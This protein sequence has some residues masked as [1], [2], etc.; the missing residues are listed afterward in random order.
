MASAAPS[1]IGARTTPWLLAAYCV[2]LALIGFW[3][4]PVD[5][6]AA[7]TLADLFRFLH[8][9]GVPHWIN[10]NFVEFSANILLFVPFGLLV[11]MVSPTRRWWMAVVLGFVISLGLETAQYALLS[12]RYPSGLDVLAN[13]T[14]ASLGGLTVFLVRRRRRPTL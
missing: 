2:C 10:Y 1:L 13:T 6:P 4:T 11:A 9:N 7:G 12:E 14:G 8:S 5:R 3:P